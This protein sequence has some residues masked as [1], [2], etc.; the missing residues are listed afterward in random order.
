VFFP[1]KRFGW[2]PP[3]T[4]QGCVFLALWGLSFAAVLGSRPNAMNFL[5]SLVLVGFLLFVASIEDR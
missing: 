3:D 2:G 4:W 1:R 5:G